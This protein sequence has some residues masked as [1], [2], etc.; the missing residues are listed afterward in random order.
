M[1]F[2]YFALLKFLLHTALINIFLFTFLSHKTCYKSFAIPIAYTGYDGCPSHHRFSQAKLIFPLDLLKKHQPLSSSQWNSLEFSHSSLTPFRLFL[3]MF[4]LL[5]F[6][7]AHKLLEGFCR[8]S[9]D[10]SMRALPIS[11]TLNN[12]L[13]SL[14]E[15][16]CLFSTQNWGWNMQCQLDLWNSLYFF[17]LASI[18]IIMNVVHIHTQTFLLRKNYSRK[19][20]KS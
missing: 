3:Q 13:L 16:M 9:S 14:V 11:W 12:S 7:L 15:H 10:S 2:P 8:D 4:L 6:L 1:N 18:I 20:T 5:H 17:P 19:K